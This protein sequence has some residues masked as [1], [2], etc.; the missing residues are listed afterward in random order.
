MLQLAGGRDTFH[1]KQKK[2]R[3][4]LR[5][6]YIDSKKKKVHSLVSSSLVF[7]LSNKQSY[8]KNSFLANVSY[9]WLLFLS[10]PKG[11]E[12]SSTSTC[13]LEEKV[14]SKRLAYKKSKMY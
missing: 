11:L 6:E 12:Q 14:S 9:N 5:Q 2:R 1:Q 13:I 4:V 7:D 10:F 3:S 8:G